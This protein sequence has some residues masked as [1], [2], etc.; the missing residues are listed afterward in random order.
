MNSSSRARFLGDEK[1]RYS[2]RMAP[3][4]RFVGEEEVDVEG[5]E[6]EEE[7]GTAQSVRALKAARVRK[8]ATM[9]PVRCLP[10]LQWMSTG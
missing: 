6:E 2:E 9:Q 4:P 3:L 8:A 5:E 7:G 1:R 10:L